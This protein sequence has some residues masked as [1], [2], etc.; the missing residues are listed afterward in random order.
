MN[1]KP[2]PF[3]MLDKPNSTKLIG[4]LSTNLFFDPWVNAQ[5]P[6]PVNPDHHPCLYEFICGQPFSESGDA[7]LGIQL[8]QNCNPV[9]VNGI[10]F[11]V[12][13]SDD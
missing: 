4:R 7:R 11:E 6:T 2:D 5:V 9:L 1:A 3:A 13:V 8:S 10:T 12:V